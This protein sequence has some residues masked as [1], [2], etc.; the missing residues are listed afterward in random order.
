MFHCGSKQIEFI[1]EDFIIIKTELILNLNCLVFFSFFFL[2]FNLII[3]KNRNSFLIY[4]II[5]EN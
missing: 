1:N 5:M 3:E 4:I 2:Q